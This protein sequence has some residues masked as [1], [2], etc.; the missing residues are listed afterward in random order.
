M[1]TQQKRLLACDNNLKRL[2]QH[3][4]TLASGTTSGNQINIIPCVQRTSFFLKQANKNYFLNKHTTDKST[5]E[6]DHKTR[7]KKQGY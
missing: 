5:T 6:K 7:E 2:Y 1:H 4:H 3:F